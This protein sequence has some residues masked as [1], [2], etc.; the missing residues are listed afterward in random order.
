MEHDRPCRTRLVVIALAAFLV[1]N[2]SASQGPVLMPWRE[3]GLAHLDDPRPTERV[4]RSQYWAG[5]NRYFPNVEN[6]LELDDPSLELYREPLT[7]RAVVDFFTSVVGDEEIVMPVLYYADQTEVPPT[8]AFS[9]A[10]VESSYRRKAVNRNVGGSVDK[11]VFQLNSRTFPHLD[12]SDFFDPETNA[13]HAL[14]YLRY[15]LN[16][17]GGD[18]RTAVAIYNAGEGRVLQGRTPES[19]Q[20]YVRDIFSYRESM[21]RNF[22]VFIE[23]EFPPRQVDVAG[24][25]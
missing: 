3:S 2:S 14:H 16:R 19:T 15:A 20:R 8:L 6:Y 24:A 11:G 21:L 18:E 17:A 12:D 25:D 4:S 7:R 1:T 5:S 23:R 10:F 22:R 9:L 13:Y